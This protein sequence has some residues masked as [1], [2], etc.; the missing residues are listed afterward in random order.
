[1]DSPN[2]PSSPS[3][4]P[5]PSPAPAK[6]KIVLLTGP[7]GCGKTALTRRLGLP[8]VRLDDFYLDGDHPGLPR[9]FG[10]VDWDD[11][12]SWDGPGALEALTSLARQGR[13]E[14]PVYDIPSNAR[15]GTGL[16]DCVG[17]AIVIA[18]GIFAAQLVEGCRAAGILADAIYLD[19]PALVTFWFR[20]LRDIAESRKPLLTLIRRGFALMRAE[21]RLHQQ[22]TSLGCR[23]VSVS[24]AEACIRTLAGDHATAKLECLEQPNST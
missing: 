22:W 8:V 19:R 4:S 11:P 2:P 18:E 3:S 23:A 6:T 20:L 5:S 9:A 12:A 17:S 21:P 24:D 14:V 7:S 10:I 13:V 15:T 1:M 16:V